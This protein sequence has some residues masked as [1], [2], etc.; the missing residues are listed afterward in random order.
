MYWKSMLEC[1]SINIELPIDVNELYVVWVNKLNQRNVP[2]GKTQTISSCFKHWCFCDSLTLYLSFS[3]LFPP[4]PLVV[5]LIVFAFVFLLIRAW[6]LIT[7]ISLMSKCL[8][9]SEWVSGKV[10]NRPGQL[11]RE[12]KMHPRKIPHRPVHFL[13]NCIQLKDKWAPKE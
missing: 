3:L 13:S 1:M 4:S 5:I 6:L 8:E 12:H 2:P 10:T 11:K 7:H 9:V